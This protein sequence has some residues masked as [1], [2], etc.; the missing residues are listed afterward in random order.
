MYIMRP[1]VGQAR[2]MTSSSQRAKSVSAGHLKGILPTSMSWC[3]PSIAK[4]RQEDTRKNPV[5]LAHCQ[6]IDKIEA[7]H[8]DAQRLVVTGKDRPGEVVEPLPTDG[9]LILLSEAV[10]RPH[11]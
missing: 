8:P 2:S 3:D 6:V 7:K 1:Q 4:V 10:R 5:F 9:A 11:R